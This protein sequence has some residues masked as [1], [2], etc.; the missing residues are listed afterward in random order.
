MNYMALA[1]G[2]VGG[3]NAADGSG[4]DTKSSLIL[5]FWM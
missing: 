2:C 3:Q 5:D 4:A 1:L